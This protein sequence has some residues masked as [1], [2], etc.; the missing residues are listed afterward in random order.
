MPTDCLG[1]RDV[2][3]SDVIFEQFEATEDGEQEDGLVLYAFIASQNVS[4]TYPSG[5]AML[6]RK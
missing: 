1:L 2:T 6:C 5:T 4:W 3:A